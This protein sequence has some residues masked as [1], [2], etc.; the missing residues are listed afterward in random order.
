MH[1]LVAKRSHIGHT[2]TKQPGRGTEDQGPCASG[3]A[4]LS[5]AERPAGRDAAGR[6]TAGNRIG[7][8]FP[9]GN[10]AA[11][12]H[13]GRRLQLGHETPLD[14]VRRIDLHDAVLTDLGGRAEVS[15]V[16]AELVADFAA[17]VVLRDVAYAHLAAVGPLTRAGRRRAV[18]DLYLQ[19]SARA[20]RLA[21]QIGLRRVPKPAPSSFSEAILQAPELTSDE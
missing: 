17:A 8:R 12:V 18:V 5:V 13:G 15:A 2:E 3:S 21:A 4:P 10:V 6:F 14:E 16:L 1:D 9:P 11:L 19:A 7:Q 20:E